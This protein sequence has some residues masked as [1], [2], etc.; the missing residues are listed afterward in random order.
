MGAFFLDLQDLDDLDGGF[1]V[2]EPGFGVLKAGD[3]DPVQH[4]SREELLP[5]SPVVRSVEAKA[6]ENVCQLLFR[7]RERHGLKSVPGPRPLLKPPTFLL[8]VGVLCTHCTIQLLWL[9]EK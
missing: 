8:P 7:Q 4:G 9:T 2:E 5:Q 6:F 3:P 1:P